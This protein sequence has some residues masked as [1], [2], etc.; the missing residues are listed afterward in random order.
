MFLQCIFVYG[1]FFLIA[2]KSDGKYI[3]H[4]NVFFQCQS[5]GMTFI[6]L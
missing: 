5:V 6:F 2:A 1:Y 4:Y 3:Q